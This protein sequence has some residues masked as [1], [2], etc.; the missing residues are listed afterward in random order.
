MKAAKTLIAWTPA[1][2]EPFRVGTR[3][4]APPG[5]VGIGPLLWREH[6]IDWAEPYHCTGGAAE[7]DRRK[8]FG[9]AQQFEVMMEWYA[10]VYGYGLAPY[11]VHRAFLL[12]DEYQSIIK[13]KG[14]GPAKGE[15]GHDP[16]IS[17]GRAVSVPPLEID[18][19]HAYGATHFWPKQVKVE[20]D[21]A[22]LDRIEQQQQGMR[23]VD[24]AER[25]KSDAEL[26]IEMEEEE[27][28]SNADIPH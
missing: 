1:G 4:I 12:I 19:H 23:E 24:D 11:I 8:L 14:W 26:M 25:W 18:I 27:R 5:S 6:D 7:V 2:A 28:R 17:Y 16:N 13:A 15:P 21:E 3:L 9:R 20:A 22:V 10:L